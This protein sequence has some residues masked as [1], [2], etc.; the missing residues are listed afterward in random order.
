LINNFAVSLEAALQFAANVKEA[1]HH[2]L[3]EW[4]SCVSRA[5][6]SIAKWIEITKISLKTYTMKIFA[7]IFHCF[8]KVEST[9]T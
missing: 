1:V 6:I 5:V 8:P 3:E 2:N 4:C 7:F 9:V